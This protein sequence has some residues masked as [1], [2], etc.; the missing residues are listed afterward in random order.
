MEK[1]VPDIPISI[2]PK[3]LLYGVMEPCMITVSKK[4]VCADGTVIEDD[5]WV[6][7]LEMRKCFEESMEHMKKFVEEG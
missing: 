2:I 3:E 4:T 1:C 6:E 7:T 5:H